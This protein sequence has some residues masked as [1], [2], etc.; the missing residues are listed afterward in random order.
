[1]A[2]SLGLDVQALQIEEGVEVL[3]GNRIPEAEEIVL[4]DT[5]E[6]TEWRQRWLARL[7][8][9]PETEAASRQLM[10]RKQSGAHPAVKLL[11]FA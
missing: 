6:F 9:Q 1:L 8:R 7:G 10:H 11:I 2:I 3:A 5:A 4:A